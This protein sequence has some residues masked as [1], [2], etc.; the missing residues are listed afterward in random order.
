MT[1]HRHQ[2][3]RGAITLIWLLGQRLEDD[4][5]NSRGE[6]RHKVAEGRWVLI[7]MLERQA[8][9]RI[10]FKGQLSRDHLVK[11][12]AKR[13]DVRRERRRTRVHSLL[14]RNVLWGAKGVTDGDLTETILQHGQAKVA[15]NRIA[16]RVQ[17]D[18]ARLNIPVN[19][20]LRVGIIQ[21]GGEL[22]HRVD[23]FLWRERTP[24][25]S[26]QVDLDTEIGPLDIFHDQVV[27]TLVTPK[28]VD[29]DD[30]GM[31]QGCDGPRLTLESRG[32]LRIGLQV[33]TQHFDS[34]VAVEDGVD[35]FVDLRH[36]TLTYSIEDFIRSEVLTDKRI[37][38]YHE[39]LRC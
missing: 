12:A 28:I 10:G 21:R 20:T 14:R 13:I 33:T 37:V 38:E 26:S 9:R 4:H 34:H 29:L 36:A 22:L 15:Q 24:L 6:V 11:D 27:A 31:T 35:A 1:Q 17:Q 23:D 25:P 8:D 32:D 16:S 19:H 30:V 39:Y 18:V 2:C 5:L 3:L 7:D